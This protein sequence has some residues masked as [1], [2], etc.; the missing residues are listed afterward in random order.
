MKE[1]I[2]K[3]NWM[4]GLPAFSLQEIS[5]VDWFVMLAAMAFLFVAFV[6]ETSSSRGTGR[7]YIIKVFWMTF[8]KPVMSS[9]RDFM[10]ITCPVPSWPLR[11]GIFLSICWG[12]FLRESCRILLSISCGISFCRLFCI[13]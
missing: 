6:E 1:K 10:P 3:I 7:F 5:K 12:G 2:K 13:L 8:T 9:L 11:F 4:K